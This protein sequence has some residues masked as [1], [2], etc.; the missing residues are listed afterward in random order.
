MIGFCT[1][2]H[3]TTYIRVRLTW[4]IINESVYDECLNVNSCAGAMVTY[5]G[6]GNTLKGGGG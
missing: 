5:T 4:W 6:K 1:K 3:K 2:F